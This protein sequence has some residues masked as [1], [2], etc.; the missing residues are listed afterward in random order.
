MPHPSENPLV[1]VGV[2]ST[3]RQSLSNS[4]AGDFRHVHSLTCNRPGTTWFLDKQQCP[5][6]PSGAGGNLTLDHTSDHVLSPG[7]TMRFAKLADFRG[8]TEEVLGLG[9]LGRTQGPQFNSS[10]FVPLM[11]R[12]YR[13]CARIRALC[14]SI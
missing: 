14:G 6:R 1:P 10:E 12:L 3:I 7:D 8:V 11:S 2:Q 4:L 9:Q 13:F 5:I